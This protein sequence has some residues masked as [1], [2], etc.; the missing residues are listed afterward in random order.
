MFARKMEKMLEEIRE[1]MRALADE[2]VRAGF[3]KFIQ[4]NQKS[5]GVKMPVLNELAKKYKDGGFELAEELWESGA[6]E[7]RVLAA[8]LIGKIAKKNPA[9]TISLVKKFSAEIDNW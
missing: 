6:F 1:H 8:K 9:K 5:Y 4:G 3:E 2:K 7:E